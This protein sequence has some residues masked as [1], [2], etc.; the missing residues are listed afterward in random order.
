MAKIHYEGEIDIE[1]KC[2][3]CFEDLEFIA[4][5][6]SMAASSEEGWWMKDK[7]MGFVKPCQNCINRKATAA[8]EAALKK[9]GVIK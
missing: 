1:F 7:M 9:A 8:I 4:S 2:G 6:I 3:S 5:G